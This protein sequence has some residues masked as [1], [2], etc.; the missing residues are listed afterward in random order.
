MLLTGTPNEVIEQVAEWRNQGLRYAVLD[1]LSTLQP[2]LR[3]GVA[4][5]LPFTRILRQ[6][7]KL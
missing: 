6:L 2:S 4:A 7:R 3:R 5:S 1:N